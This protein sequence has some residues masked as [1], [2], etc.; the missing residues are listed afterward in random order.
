M[1]DPPLL[2]DGPVAGGVALVALALGIVVARR[3]VATVPDS[4]PDRGMCLSNLAPQ[5]RALA[6]RTGALAGLAE[7][8]RLGRRAVAVT[9]DD[10]DDHLAALLN[11]TGTLRQLAEPNRRP[12]Y[13]RRGREVRAHSRRTRPR[14]GAAPHPRSDPWWGVKV[15]VNQRPIT[16]TRPPLC[17]TRPGARPAQ[18]RTWAAR[19]AGSARAG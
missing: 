7:A 15:R 17:R 8:A 11:L 18:R 2:V 1:I 14:G 3:A 12:G 9:V 4:D 19:S 10:R 16:N 6:E 5:L 13:A